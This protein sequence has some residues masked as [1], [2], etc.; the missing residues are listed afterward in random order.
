MGWFVIS[1]WLV[2]TFQLLRPAIECSHEPSVGDDTLMVSTSTSTLHDFDAAST[3]PSTEI[4]RFSP[5]SIISFPFY[6]LREMRSGFTNKKAPE[7][8]PRLA[9]S[10]VAKNHLENCNTNNTMKN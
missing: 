2:V 9:G 4:I 5:C 3:L 10:G 8:L 6:F 1:R 7:P